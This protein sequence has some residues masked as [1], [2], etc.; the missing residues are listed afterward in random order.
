[1]FWDEK[2]LL[3]QSIIIIVTTACSLVSI[4]RYTACFFVNIRN[5]RFF[6]FE[7]FFCVF[8]EKE[9]TFAPLPLPLGDTITLDV[10]PQI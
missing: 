1:M 5:I 7:S 8:E 10:V 6:L 9:T 2:Q 3:W 4:Y